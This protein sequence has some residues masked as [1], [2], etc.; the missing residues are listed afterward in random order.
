[1]AWGVVGEVAEE[2]CSKSSVVEVC[3]AVLWCVLCGRETHEEHFYLSFFLFQ[4]DGT[5]SRILPRCA[6]H[7]SPPEQS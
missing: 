4:G 2:V 1:M 3:S 5:L 7:G 6:R